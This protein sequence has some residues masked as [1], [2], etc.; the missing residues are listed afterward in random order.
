MVARKMLGQILR[1]QGAVHEGMVQEAL[2][3]QQDSGKRIGEVLIQL[4][5]LDKHQLAEALAKQAGLVFV[6]GDELTPDPEVLKRVDAATARVYGV[7]PLRMEGKKLLLVL[8]DPLNLHVIED[9]SL[10]AGCELMAAVS[11]ADAVADAIEKAYDITTSGLLD[12]SAISDA[13]AEFSAFGSTGFDL[14]DKEAMANAGREAL[15]LH[16]IP[17]RQGQGFGHPLGAV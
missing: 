9:L 15:E 13:V 3:V 16:S 5:Y 12:Q 6:P 1:E 10:S 2:A 11:D 4:G 17:S 14:E 8:S 7:L